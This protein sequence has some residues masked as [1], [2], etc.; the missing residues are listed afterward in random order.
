MNQTFIEKMTFGYRFDREREVISLLFI[1]YFMIVLFGAIVVLLHAQAEELVPVSYRYHSIIL[2]SLVIIWLIRIRLFTLA[3]VLMLTLIPF[4]LIILPPLAGLTSDEFYFWFPYVPI[5][6]SL[7]PQFILHTSRHRVALIITLVVYFLMAL[8]IDD[9]LIF[10]SDGSERIIPFIL[11]NRFYYNLIPVVIYLFVNLALGLLFAKIYNYQQIMLRQQDELIQAEK[12]ASLGILTTGIAHE[13][14][15]PLNFISGGLH[16]LNTLKLEYQKLEGE[17]IPEKKNIQEQMDKIMGNSMEGV[18]RASDIITSLKF[19]ANPGK[20]VKRDHNLE[21]LLYAV[22]LTVEKKLPYHISISKDIPHRFIIHCY[23]EQLQQV[24]INILMNA[25]EAIEEMKEKKQRRIHITA[26]ETRRDKTEATCISIR[27]N[28]PAIPK[29]KI[30]K[31]FDPFFTLKDYG[32]G[33]GLGM[34]I[35]YM[36]VSEHHGWIEARNEG[37]NVVFDVILPKN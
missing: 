11:E 36:I 5:A 2:L 27:N 3:R 7:I 17:L 13:I 15:N 32:K 22:M 12:M 18:Q 23:E 26:F 28:G 21:Q 20:A 6:I 19:F 33:K 14:N 1:S 8:F 35:S 4:I 29:D 31:I 24:F 25:I 37:D 9:Y 10:L 34:A 16:A 30:G